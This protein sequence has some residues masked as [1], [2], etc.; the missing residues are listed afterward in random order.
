MPCG[1]SLEHCTFTSG[2][3]LR[4]SLVW[5]DGF[6]TCLW[7]VVGQTMANSQ[8]SSSHF[9]CRYGSPQTGE[10]PQIRMTM[11]YSHIL[12]GY[13]QCLWSET[14]QA[15]EWVN[16]YQCLLD[17]VKPPK[18][19]LLN[20]SWPC[21][22]RDSWRSPETSSKRKRLSLWQD[23]TVNNSTVPRMFPAHNTYLWTDWVG[24]WLG[25]SVPT[26]PTAPGQLTWWLVTESL[27]H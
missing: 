27:T 26:D 4:W 12:L 25:L 20:A 1:P 6:R 19:V 11:S 18:G 23:L 7:V 13:W 17:A 8:E 16:L 14:R 21:L 9:F 24:T 3:K 2:R 10:T 22:A 15:S 5:S